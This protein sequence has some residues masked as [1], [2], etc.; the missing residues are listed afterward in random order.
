[1]KKLVM[2]IIVGAL[3]AG[4]VPSAWAGSAAAEAAHNTGDYA[5]ALRLYME[6]GSPEAL[7]NVGMLYFNG[8]GVN[9]DKREALGWFRKAAERG[10][11]DAQISLG[12]MF[13]DVGIL[14]AAVVCY[15]LVLFFQR[16][17]ADALPLLLLVALPQPGRLGRA[18][19]DHARK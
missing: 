11:I 6:D 14:G 4:L 10:N 8:E 15:L 18:F 12:E 2:L 17:R 19:S 9:Q 5:T 13:K 7:Y 1:M 16:R 3:C